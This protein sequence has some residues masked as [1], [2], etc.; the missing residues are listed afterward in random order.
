MRRGVINPQN[1]HILCGPK[2]RSPGLSSPSSLDHRPARE[3]SLAPRRLRNR[4]ILISTGSA[5]AL[6][7]RDNPGLKPQTV[8]WPVQNARTKQC[9][10]VPDCSYFQ[11]NP[12][13]K[14]DESLLPPYE[15]FRPV[16]SLRFSDHSCRRMAQSGDAVMPL[17]NIAVGESLAI[18]VALALNSAGCAATGSPARIRAWLIVRRATKLQRWA[19]VSQR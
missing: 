18:P 4:R 19:S 2:S 5:L 8:L 10:S 7:S 16:V 15:Q 12:Q 9:D 14:P 1:G 11:R 17:E 3:L 13:T 6:F